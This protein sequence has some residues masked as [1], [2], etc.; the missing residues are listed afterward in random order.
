HEE[1]P[2]VVRLAIHTEE[3]HSVTFDA[4][5]TAEDI[6]AT[7]QTKISTLMAYFNAN[8]EEQE[9]AEQDPAN[10]V[11]FARSLLY[12][13]FPGPWKTSKWKRCER[14]AHAVGRMYFVH[15]TAGE[16]FYVQL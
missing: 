1:K 6:L 14:G 11:T 2:N 12:Q 7:V 10:A 4:E 5:A 3:A 9:K 15:P 13:E 8:K 16:R